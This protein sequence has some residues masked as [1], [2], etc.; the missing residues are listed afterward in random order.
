MQILMMVNKPDYQKRIENFEKWYM[1]TRQI[2]SK[3]F[4]ELE[5]IKDNSDY[6]KDYW[7]AK[8]LRAEF[9]KHSK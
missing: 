7:V 6:T 9:R 5:K 4:D 2:I 8:I 3:K 1:E